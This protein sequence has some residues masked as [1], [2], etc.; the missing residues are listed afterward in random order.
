MY[1]DI[2]ISMAEERHVHELQALNAE[3]C[4]RI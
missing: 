4:T 3:V 1:I 2:D